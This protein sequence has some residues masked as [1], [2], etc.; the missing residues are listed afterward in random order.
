MYLDC[1]TFNYYVFIAAYLCQDSLEK[2]VL[3]L[4]GGFLVK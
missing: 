4:N 1:V 2:W 3:N